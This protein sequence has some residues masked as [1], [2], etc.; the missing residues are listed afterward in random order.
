MVCGL[1]DGIPLSVLLTCA[2][3]ALSLHTYELIGPF[4]LTTDKQGLAV[5]VCTA[6]ILNLEGRAFA[7]I[8]ANRENILACIVP[9]VGLLSR[10]H[11]KVSLTAR[12]QTVTYLLLTD[13][14]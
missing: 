3:L 11:W 9:T 13:K 4:E 10:P 6:I 7:A 12:V 2:L 5:D 14:N 8:T 1:R